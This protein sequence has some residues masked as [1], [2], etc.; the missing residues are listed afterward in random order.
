M[1]TTPRWSRTMEATTST[2]ASRTFS[3]PCKVKDVR[4][5]SGVSFVWPRIPPPILTSTSIQW[6]YW[7]YLTAPLLLPPPLPRFLCS[8]H[9]YYPCLDFDVHIAV[10]PASFHRLARAPSGLELDPMDLNFMRWVISRS[11]SLAGFFLYNFYTAARQTRRICIH[12]SEQSLIDRLTVFLKNL[13]FSTPWGALTISEEIFLTVELRRPFFGLQKFES[14][15]GLTRLKTTFFD[16][17]SVVSQ[18]GKSLRAF[19]WDCW[20][21]SP[22]PLYLD[23]PFASFRDHDIVFFLHACAWP[24][25]W[26]KRVGGG[27]KLSG[28]I[29]PVY[30][31]AQPPYKG[32]FVT[33]WTTA[34]RRHV[35][36]HPSTVWRSVICVPSA[37]KVTRKRRIPVDFWQHCSG[38]PSTSV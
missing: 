32:N 29:Y 8:V 20:S 34:R 14:L 31:S 10:D 27:A 17:I 15:S 6:H 37:L 23:I 35:S 33:M 11:I 1:L 22:L 3:V 2:L 18:S 38:K 7:T 5:S 26:G 36:V 19:I 13:S 12:G 24:E 25:N 30:T 21:C 16:Q 4:P 9:L 28:P